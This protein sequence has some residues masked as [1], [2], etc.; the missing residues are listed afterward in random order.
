MAT[1]PYM[2]QG[3][4]LTWVRRAGDFQLMVRAHPSYRL[5]FGVYPRLLAM[6]ITNEIKLTQNRTIKFGGSYQAFLRE[7]KISDVVWEIANQL[8]LRQHILEAN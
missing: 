4:I 5:P 3:S 8:A 1:L 6:W 7:L 2:D